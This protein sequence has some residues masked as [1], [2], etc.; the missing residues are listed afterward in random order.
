MLLV[1]FVYRSIWLLGKC[2]DLRIAKPVLPADGFAF[3]AQGG[4]L[5]CH[6]LSTLK[7]ER[8]LESV[9]ILRLGVNFKL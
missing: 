9:P 1:A 8:H 3:Y 2:A 5:N 4:G 7:G 6:I